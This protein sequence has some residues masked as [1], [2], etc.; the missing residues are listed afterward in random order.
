LSLPLEEQPHKHAS[1]PVQVLEEAMRIIH[2]LRRYETS[3]QQEAKA[4]HVSIMEEELM[5]RVWHPSR[6]ERWVEAGVHM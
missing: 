3:K 5:Q 1:G 6:V 4:R 2:Q